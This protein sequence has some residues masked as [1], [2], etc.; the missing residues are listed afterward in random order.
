LIKKFFCSHDFQY[1]NTEI[2]EID[3]NGNE[4]PTRY[5]PI[6]GTHRKCSKCDKKQ[7]LDMTPGEWRF[8]N[9]NFNFP[10]HGI[11]FKAYSNPFGFK[12][13]QEIR[14]SKLD[15]LLGDC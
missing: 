4:I 5:S 12:T 7:R 3:V 6:A 10:K 11:S 8:K 9:C 13:K 15:Q 2:L 14:D 1:W